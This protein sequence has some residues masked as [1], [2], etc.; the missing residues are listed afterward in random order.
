[1]RNLNKTLLLSSL[2]TLGLIG[3]SVF[4]EEEIDPETGY[5]VEEVVVTSTKRETNLMETP[6]AVTA[7]SQ[8]AL[9]KEGVK[10]A[11]D[12]ATLVPNLQIG[13]SPSDSGVQVAIRGITSN[14]FTE[15][16]DPT[17]AIHFDG[18][19]SPRPQGG[20]ALMHDVER[21][22]IN[23]GPQGTLFGRNSTAGSIN[24]LSSRPKFDKVSG[25]VNLEVGDRQQRTIK[26]WVNYPVNDQI[27]LRASVL[28]DTSD[29]YLNQSQ[30]FFDLALDTNKDGDFDDEFDVAP[31]GIPNVDQRRNRPVGKDKAYG[32]TDRKGARLSMR[33]SP[34]QTM[35]WNIIYDYF[36]DESPGSLSLKDCEKAAGTFFACDHDQWDV[37]VNVPGEFDM[38]IESWR[39]IF[40]WDVTEGIT[41]EHRVAIADQQRSQ[42]Y[43]GTTA[44]ADA[45][46]PAL[47][48][49]GTGLPVNDPAVLNSLGF[50]G[51]ILQPWGDTALTTRYSDYDSL[52]SE[53]QFKSN[54]DAPLQWIAGLAYVKEDNTIIFD[55]EDPF[56]CGFIRPLA[57]SYV[58][59]D[60][61]LRSKAAFAQFD[62]AFNERLNL[63]AGYRYTEDEKFDRNGSNHETI[64]YWV[65][66]NLY[67][68]DG[69]F[70]HESYSLLGVVPFWS[71][72][73]QSDDLGPL[74]GTLGGSEFTRRVPGT[75]NTF[76]ASWAKGTWKL[77]FDYLVNDD[78][79]V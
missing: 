43:D 65:N 8:E 20:L 64:G 39:S 49:A 53:L 45:D 32:A 61:G 9:D 41:L 10:S 57:L 3:P 29:S 21:V 22:E 26:G 35:D 17:V 50:G 46:H 14:N 2:L 19:Y 44:Y 24:I 5:V 54:S 55:V 27:A 47:G 16:G 69:S 67:D 4:A 28:K 75:D 30:D 52:V 33:Y 15:L 60:R 23:R 48:I 38:S 74:D 76:N 77:G 71:E 34:T 70:W 78:T 7:L 73:Y 25:N 31:D 37:Q 42:V 13:L 63:T 51:Y 58:Q 11:L 12:L 72:Y 6:L 40:E 62:Y 18:L 79:F 36:K 66:P 1:M 59:P 56:C 68:A